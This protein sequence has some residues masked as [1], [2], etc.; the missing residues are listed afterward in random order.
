MTPV[1]IM[2]VDT[3]ATRL[4]MSTGGNRTME[5]IDI[6]GKQLK[7][8]VTDQEVSPEELANIG[9]TDYCVVRINRQG[10]IEVRRP[11]SWEVIG[12]LIGD[13]EHRLPEETGMHWL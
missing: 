10:D 6:S 3:P 5:F 4:A 1:L 8:L 9:L 11:E 12:G 7:E 2:N 13:F